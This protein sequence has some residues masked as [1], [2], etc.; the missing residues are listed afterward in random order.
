MAKRTTVTD[1]TRTGTTTPN[2]PDWIQ[3]PAQQIA[4]GVS[5]VLNQGAGAFTP[6]ITQ[7]QQSVWDKGAAGFGMPD[8]GESN[9]LLRGGQDITAGNVQ[10]ESLLSGLENYYN[11]Y[12]EQILNPVLSDYDVQSGQTRAAQAA[13]AARNAAFRGSRYGIQ[14]GETEGQLARGRA[15][16][17]GGLLKSLFETSTGLSSQDAAR[18][19]Q[20]AEQNQQ[21]QLQAAQANQSAELQRARELAANAATASESLRG[22]VKLQAD[23]AAQEAEARNRQAQYPLEFLQQAGGLL[24]GINPGQYIG[25]NMT[26]VLHGTSKETMKQ[27][28]GD[29]F[30]QALTAAAANAPKAAAGGG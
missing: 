6:Q 25:Q 22:G 28:L 16:T 9:D 8:F 30:G 27:S 15:A 7:G 14:E 4:G 19:Q 20:A 17:E 12:K 29:W 1:Q 24:Q 5:G 13:D 11:P 3:Q 26:D 23:L 2:V 21:A 18:R 10:G